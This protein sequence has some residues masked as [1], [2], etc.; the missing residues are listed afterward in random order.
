MTVARFDPAAFEGLDEP[1][2]RYFRHAL[3][4]G[5]PLTPGVRLDLSGRIR[6]GAWLRFRSTWQ[7]DGR[8]FSWRAVAGPGPFALL[9]VHDQFA[10][11]RGSMDVRLRSLEL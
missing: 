5:V 10:G 11:G 2:V 8:S 4:D 3:A 9:R 7:G 1:V 6:V